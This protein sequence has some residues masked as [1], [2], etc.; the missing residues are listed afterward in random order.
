RVLADRILAS[1]DV[2]NFSFKGRIGARIRQLGI[3]NVLLDRMVIA[4]ARRRFN[5]VYTQAERDLA[6]AFFRGLPQYDSDAIARLRLSAFYLEKMEQHKLMA[7]YLGPKDLFLSEDG[8]IHLNFGLE[9][10]NG[11]LLPQAVILLDA[12][13]NYI[14]KN[15]LGRQNSQ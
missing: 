10:T 8:L 11:G 13:D 1:G 15:R 12:D 9:A 7:H 2:S 5:F 6:N 3:K 14:L 4:A